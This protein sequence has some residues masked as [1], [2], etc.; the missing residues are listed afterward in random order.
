MVCKGDTSRKATIKTGNATEIASYTYSFQ[1]QVVL[2]QSCDLDQLRAFVSKKRW[3]NFT[4]AS[5]YAD[6]MN[7]LIKRI[8]GHVLAGNAGSVSAVCV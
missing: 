6:N 4:D 2:H 3:M 5:K 1:L 8:K 7:Q